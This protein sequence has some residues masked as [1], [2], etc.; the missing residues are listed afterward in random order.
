MKDAKIGMKVNV[1]FFKFNLKDLE[2]IW[3]LKALNPPEPI[4]AH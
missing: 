1:Y 4:T 3:N 2:L